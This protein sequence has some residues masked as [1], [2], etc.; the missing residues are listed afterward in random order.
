[1]MTTDDVISG[2]GDWQIVL[3][4]VLAKIKPVNNGFELSNNFP[5]YD[6]LIDTLPERHQRQTLIGYIRRIPLAI[7]PGGNGSDGVWVES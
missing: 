7:F 1:M 3:D 5:S 4:F 2:N 6:P